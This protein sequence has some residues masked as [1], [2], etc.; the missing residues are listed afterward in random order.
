MRNQRFTVTIAQINSGAVITIDPK[1]TYYQ[2]DNFNQIISTQ[3]LYPI[4]IQIINDT[5]SGVQFNAIL[6]EPEY[7]EYLVSSANF[8]FQR[9]PKGATLQPDHSNFE[10]CYMFLIQGYET[11]AIGNLTIEFIN[12]R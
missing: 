11:T 12:Y 7:D 8:A 4:D 9:I 2:Y 5:G 10:R 3:Y 1:M 6:T